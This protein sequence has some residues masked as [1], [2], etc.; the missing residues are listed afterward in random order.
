MKNQKSVLL[1]AKFVSKI[2]SEKEIEEMLK[3]V[4][5]LDKE[6][7]K[8][9]KEKFLSKHT[10]GKSHFFSDLPIDMLREIYKNLSPGK[11]FYLRQ[12]N[13][14]KYLVAMQLLF[15]QRSWEACRYQIEILKGWLNKPVEKL[16]ILSEDEEKNKKEWVGTLH[17]S[18]SS[19]PDVIYKIYC[20]S[21]VQKFLGEES[22]K[23]GEL[24][25]TKM[26]TAH[27]SLLKEDI[28]F[29]I[30]FGERL[31]RILKGLIP[32]MRLLE[33]KLLLS[34]LIIKLDV[35]IRNE[36]FVEATLDVLSALVSQLT[37]AEKKVL[38]EELTKKL[39]PNLMN[40]LNSDDPYACK[41]MG[42]ILEKLIPIMTPVERTQTKLFSELIQKMGDNRRYVY[43]AALTLF[44]G[45]LPSLI[46]HEKLA[47][48]IQLITVT[49]SENRNKNAYEGG[50]EILGELIS[51]MT[52]DEIH[53]WI[54]KLM[55]RVDDKSKNTREGVLRVLALLIPQ[56]E[57]TKK[58]NS[59]KELIPKL[60]A[61]LDG[62]DKDAALNV[63]EEFVSQLTNK[64]GRASV[65]TLIL[66]SIKNLSDSDEEIRKDAFRVLEK[67]TW[68]LTS[69]E[70]DT[71]TH[72]CLHELSHHDSE[73]QEE[74][75]KVLERLLFLLRPDKRKKIIGTCM[76]HLE[77]NNKI[78]EKSLIAFWEKWIFLSTIDE[79]K[80]FVYQIKTKLDNKASP[81]NE[82]PLIILEMLILQL[83]EL[84]VA[85]KKALIIPLIATL[86]DNRTSIRDKALRN[87]ALLASHLTP[88]IAVKERLIAELIAILKSVNELRNFNV[89]NACGDSWNI[90]A[91]LVPKL[92]SDEI[93]EVGLTF[94]LIQNLLGS[95]KYAIYSGA[96]K[97]LLLL[98]PQWSDDEKK[99]LLAQQI[100]QLSM[101]RRDPVGNNV[102]EI[103]KLFSSLLSNDEKKQLI[104]EQRGMI[105]GDSYN[106]RIDAYRGLKILVPQ[107]ILDKATKEKLVSELMIQLNAG[108]EEVQRSFI[109]EQSRAVLNDSISSIRSYVLGI[110]EALIPQLTW[111]EKIQLIP[112]LMVQMDK[113]NEWY[114]SNGLLRVLG[115][116][117]PELSTQEGALE[118]VNGPESVLLTYM[119]EAYQQCFPPNP[120]DLQELILKV[121]PFI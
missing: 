120:A 74:A 99:K 93:N 76:N 101:S 98:A 84:S 26:L 15:E 108:I 38:R 95:S 69:K 103:L 52:P 37:N 33:R 21:M 94:E 54:S 90:L 57:S 14:I 114:V 80:E 70:Q 77:E 79:K 34:E 42:K 5:G 89:T 6:E 62:E 92:T 59:V 12:V 9:F 30:F 46:S 44:R 10:N 36:H 110:L 91:A 109:T 107:A 83:F 72:Q 78:S 116:L 7:I 56:A 63:L 96:F 111:E 43:D 31:L 113:Q 88:D 61:R 121:P 47:L 102:F 66:K 22:Y 82:E 65:E 23:N 40:K 24:L 117:L 18:L 17:A 48:T 106:M 3:N 4:K 25:L 60:I 50:L 55:K 68:L 11:L 27:I 51:S 39:A 2:F 16:A 105:S 13:K 41:D 58:K 85:E 100:E 97:L 81:I 71:V 20:F 87:L 75:L 1:G 115:L 8:A 49:T 86:Q 73:L 119:V 35:G 104:N 64:D 45:V 118:N 112:G 67:L 19:S 28:T 32:L 53:M 29:I